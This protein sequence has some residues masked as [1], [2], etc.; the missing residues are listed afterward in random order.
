M[1]KDKNTFSVV[2]LDPEVSSI[3]DNIV[4]CAR[5]VSFGMTDMVDTATDETMQEATM[6][7]VGYCIYGDVINNEEVVDGKKFPINGQS[8][9]DKFMMYTSP[10]EKQNQETFNPLATMVFNSFNKSKY[11]KDGIKDMVTIFGKAVITAKGSSKYSPVSLNVSEFMEVVSS[12]VGDSYGVKEI[13]YVNKN[14]YGAN[15]S[16]N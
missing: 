1:S 8:L 6:Q 15:F 13:K 2:T 16:E 11:F 12:L 3:E 5:A 10:I 9:G 7:A 4:A 14:N